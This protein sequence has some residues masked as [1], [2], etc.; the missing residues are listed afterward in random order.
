[1]T[2]WTEYAAAWG[3][4][5]ATHALPSRPGLRPRLVAALGARGYT[6]AY[7]ALSLAALAWLIGA[8]GRAPRLPLWPQ[9]AGAAWLVLASTLPAA[10]LLAASLG[11]PNPYSFGGA[12]NHLFDPDRP[13]IVRLT[14]HPVLL[15][16][17]L[18]ALGH[19]AVNGELAHVLLFGGFAG[20]ALLG[21]RMLDRRAIRRMGAEAWR[22]ETLRLRTAPLR[23]P[24]GPR[25]LLSAAAGL[26]AVILLHRWLAG[27]P[28]WRNFLA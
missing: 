18:W 22:A 7:S 5:L 19:L 26:L 17:L 2:D 20:F 4:F 6:L 25:R 10:L 23:L 28:I 27:V 16:L 24:L 13:G 1:L 12:K 9:P 14:R 21:M 15:A 11:R 8:A 3:F